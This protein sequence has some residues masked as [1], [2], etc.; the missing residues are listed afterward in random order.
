MNISFRENPL[1]RRPIIIALVTIAIPVYVT[2]VLCEVIWK[3][4]KTM[5]AITKQAILEDTPKFK[6]TVEY[7]KE[8]W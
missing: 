1:I 2:I 5:A 8:I 7:I 6:D 3:T 4:I